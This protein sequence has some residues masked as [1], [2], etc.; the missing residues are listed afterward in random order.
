MANGQRVHSGAIAADP[1]VL[2]IGSKVHIEGMGNFTVKDTGGAIRGRR[3]DIWMPSKSAAMRFGR[4][5]V[6]LKKL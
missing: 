1:R 5:Q 2:P 4:R 6:L 3:I